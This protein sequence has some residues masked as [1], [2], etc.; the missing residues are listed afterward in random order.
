M[1]SN[2]F[3][4][5]CTLLFCLHAVSA[6]CMQRR[7]CFAV[8]PE[9]PKKIDNFIFYIF[10]YFLFVCVGRFPDQIPFPSRPNFLCKFRRHGDH[11]SFSMPEL[12]CIP[13]QFRLPLPP[14]PIYTCESY[15]CAKILLCLG[16]KGALLHHLFL[17]L[18]ITINSIQSQK[19]LGICLP[20]PV[21]RPGS[22]QLEQIFRANGESIPNC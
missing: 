10:F 9:E 20:L 3:W 18:K 6:N 12:P 2:I 7:S 19:H 11:L 4:Y 14:P 13:T 15:L 17:E 5:C 1:G 22:I 8:P 21:F 16:I